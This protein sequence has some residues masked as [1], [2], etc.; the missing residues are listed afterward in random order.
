VNISDSR[1]KDVVPLTANAHFFTRYSYAVERLWH[2]VS[3]VVC[4]RL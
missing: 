2:D 4:R 1:K 3:S